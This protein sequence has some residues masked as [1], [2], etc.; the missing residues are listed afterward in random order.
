MHDGVGWFDIVA[1]I[2]ATC[3][4]SLLEFKALSCSQVCVCMYVCMYVCVHC[5]YGGECVNLRVMCVGVQGRCE[6][7]IGI[8]PEFVDGK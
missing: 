6:D 7:T 2:S 4:N 5:V 3:I 8:F 1:V